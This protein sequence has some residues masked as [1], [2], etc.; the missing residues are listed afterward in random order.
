MKVLILKFVGKGLKLISEAQVLGF[1]VSFTV[2]LYVKY[3]RRIGFWSIIFRT[4]FYYEFFHV[5]F[6]IKQFVSY[7]NLRLNLVT[8]TGYR[9]Y[10]ILL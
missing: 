4:T 10:I 9:E 6:L 5:L 7:Y 2:V 1:K 8:R 3:Y